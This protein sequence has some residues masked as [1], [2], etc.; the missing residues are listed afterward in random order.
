[1]TLCSS[2]PAGAPRERA[3][4]EGPG[5][6]EIVPRIEEAIQVRAREMLAHPRVLLEHVAQMALLIDR[7][8]AGLLDERVRGQSA[9]P[10]AERHRDGLGEDQAVC[11]FEVL[12]HAGRIELESLEHLSEI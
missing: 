10:P 9:D 12:R 4:A 8:S 5:R 2:F 7:A 11:R 3:I 6:A 1:M